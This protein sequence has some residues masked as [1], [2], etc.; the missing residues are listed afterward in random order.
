MYPDHR[1]KDTDGAENSLGWGWARDLL[2]EIRDFYDRI[3]QGEGVVLTFLLL[4]LWIHG[5]SSRWL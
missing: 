1:Q 3:Q 4:G 2:D 5:R